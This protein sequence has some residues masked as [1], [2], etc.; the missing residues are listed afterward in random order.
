MILLLAVSKMYV[1]KIIKVDCYEENWA[2]TE[3]QTTSIQ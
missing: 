2:G 3:I 1:T